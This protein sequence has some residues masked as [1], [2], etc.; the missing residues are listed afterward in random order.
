MCLTTDGYVQL[1]KPVAVD[2]NIHKYTCNISSSHAVRDHLSYTT[3]TQPPVRN[4]NIYLAR[5][6]IFPGYTLH[7]PVSLQK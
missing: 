6:E 1:K 7:K 4:D 3:L 5:H 2:G